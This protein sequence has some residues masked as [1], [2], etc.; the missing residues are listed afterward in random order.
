MRYD[1]SA[2]A[3]EIRSELSGMGS[4]SEG[5]YLRRGYKGGTYWLA[6]HL[7]DWVVR[8]RFGVRA[9]PSYFLESYS[10]QHLSWFCYHL[11]AHQPHKLI[12]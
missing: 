2:S 7:G 11:S 1:A 8:F 3:T 5:P 4:P 10:M 12:H 9:A 6:V